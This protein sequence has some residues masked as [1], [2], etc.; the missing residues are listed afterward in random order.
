MLIF[1]L[2]LSQQVILV[3]FILRITVLCLQCLIFYNFC[4]QNDSKNFK[5]GHLKKKKTH[6]TRHSWQIGFKG[7]A[8]PNEQKISPQFTVSVWLCAARYK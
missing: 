1:S 5:A 4:S 6:D 2:A 3:C 7:S 8:H